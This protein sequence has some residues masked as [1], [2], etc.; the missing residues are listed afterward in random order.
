MLAFTRAGHKR[1]DLLRNWTRRE[2]RHARALDASNGLRDEGAMHRTALWIAALL[3]L[4]ACSRG[5]RSPTPLFESRVP[6]APL[7]A[8][9][10]ESSDGSK[11]ALRPARAEDLLRLSSGQRYKFVVLE[12]GSLTI[13]PLPAGAPNNPYAHPVLARGAPVR[14]AGGLAVEHSGDTLKKVTVDEDSEAYC[15][16]GASLEAA[17]RALVRIGV[18]SSELRVEHR[19][20][21]CVGASEHAPGMQ[22]PAQTESGPDFGQVMEEVGHDFELLGRAAK[23]RRYDFAKFQLGELQEVFHDDVPRA[24]LPRE[25]NGVD[26]KSAARAFISEYPPALESALVAR[27]AQA[28]ANAFSKTATGCNSCHAATGHAFI[29]ISATPGAAVPDLEPK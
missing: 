12:N 13:A 16:T 4:P 6:L 20:P 26:V 11:P 23:N 24:G 29:E 9:L 17:L 25:T 18:P 21:A 27:D 7:L 3:A 19:P 8:K 2:P 22:G 1:S 5:A 15:P 10:K 28:F 14:T